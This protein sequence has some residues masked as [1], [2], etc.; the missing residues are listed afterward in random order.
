[1]TGNVNS[2]EVQLAIGRVAMGILTTPYT[3]AKITAFEP[4][5][6]TTIHDAW[7]GKKLSAR[8]QQAW[9]MT[10]ALFKEAA[11]VSPGNGGYG[12]CVGGGDGQPMPVVYSN[13]AQLRLERLRDQHLHH[14]EWRL[15]GTLT[16]ENFN[17]VKLYSLQ[18]LGQQMSGYR[19]EA[20][21]R[22]AGVATLHRLMDS[23]AE[24]HGI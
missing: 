12:D 4:Q 13:S 19:D 10:M 3:G 23:L 24:F 9:A 16:M 11:G 21:A 14:H 2:L 15:L 22:A 8:H 6:K 20:Q 7:H 18:H 17:N 5:R 1:M